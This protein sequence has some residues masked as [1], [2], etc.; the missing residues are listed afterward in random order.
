MGD[1]GGVGGRAVR[2]VTRQDPA[3]GG[4][5]EGLVRRW[6]R[7]A[8]AGRRYGAGLGALPL[9]CCGGIPPAPPGAATRHPPQVQ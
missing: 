1:Y 8:E 9:R 7:W 2:E 6:P 4:A 3:R 5:G